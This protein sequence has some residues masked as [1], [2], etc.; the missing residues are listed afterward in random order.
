MGAVATPGPLARRGAQAGTH[1]IQL[2]VPARL[3][4]ML[5]ALYRL[6][7]VWALKDMANSGVARVEASRITAVE[8]VHSLR[9]RVVLSLEEHVKMVRHEAVRMAPPRV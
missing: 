4:V 3:Q 1:G 7:V 8:Q 5:L 6:G 9:K 2:D